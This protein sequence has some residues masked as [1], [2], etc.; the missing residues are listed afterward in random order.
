[1]ILFGLII[2]GIEI[3]QECIAASVI[4]GINII[5]KHYCISTYKWFLP[6]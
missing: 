1:M 4:S 6:L 3:N 2:I 5:I